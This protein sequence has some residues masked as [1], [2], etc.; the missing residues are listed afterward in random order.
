MSLVLI[1]L[2]A[3]GL[4]YSFL[5]GAFD[6]VRDELAKSPEQVAAEAVLQAN[7]DFVKVSEDISSANVVVKDK[8]SDTEETY[9]FNQVASGQFMI[10]GATSSPADFDP[11]NLDNI[12]IWVPRYSGAIGE[13]V[14]AREAIDSVMMGVITFTTTDPIATVI[15][16]YK[17]A[18]DTQNGLTSWSQRSQTINGRVM[19]NLSFSDDNKGLNLVMANASVNSPLSVQVVYVSK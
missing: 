12:P 6:E 4:G 10:E 16:E 3:A 17:Q 19:S 9:T 8:R 11:T 13:A 15:A 14:V 7:P 2:V 5:K 1:L 18:V